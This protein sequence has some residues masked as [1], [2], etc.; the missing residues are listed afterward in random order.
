MDFGS[1]VFNNV[2]LFSYFINLTPSENGFA[3]L[4]ATLVNELLRELV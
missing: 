3:E 1:C 4:S 2:S